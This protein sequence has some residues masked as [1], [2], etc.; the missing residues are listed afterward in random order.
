MVFLIPLLA[1]VLFPIAVGTNVMEL[2]TGNAALGG[3][4]FWQ[5]FASFWGMI[6]RSMTTW[7]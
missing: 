3:E 1:P 6:W 5:Q 7:L 2:L 4:T